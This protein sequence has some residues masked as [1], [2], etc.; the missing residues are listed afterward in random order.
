MSVDT[1]EM[2]FC[3]KAVEIGSFGGGEANDPVIKGGEKMD[4]GYGSY[5]TVPQLVDEIRGVIRVCKRNGAAIIFAT[6]MSNQE[7]AVEALTECGFYT[8]EPFKTR[9]D[10]TSDRRMQAWFLPV[11][12]AKA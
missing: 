8:S 3:C 5:P 6:T 4:Y 9:K 2:S 10:T 11:V 7:H 1:N 12:E